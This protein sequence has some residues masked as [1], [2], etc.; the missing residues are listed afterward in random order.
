[1]DGAR[2]TEHFFLR[3]MGFH[4]LQTKLGQ[5]AELFAGD[6]EQLGML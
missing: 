6:G 5:R 4:S 2:L 3:A 1:V